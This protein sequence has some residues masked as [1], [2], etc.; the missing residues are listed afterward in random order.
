[1]RRTSCRRWL[2]SFGLLGTLLVAAACSGGKGGGNGGSVSRSI[3]EGGTLRLG[4]SQ[5]VDSLNPFV[6]QNQ[7]AGSV[8]KNVYPYLVQFDT[9]MGVVGDFAT[10]WET[11]SDGLTWTFHTTPNAK[12]SDGQP[13]TA[14]DAAFSLRVM[15]KFKSG[16][17]ALYAGYAAGISGVQATD[18]NTLVVTYEKP[19]ATALARLNYIPILPEH[20]WSKYAKGNGQALKTFQ[21]PVPVVSGGPLVP[22]KYIKN[23]TVVLTKNANW[24]GPKVHVDEV[25]VEMFDNDDAMVSALKTGQ[26][27]AI[28]TPGVPPT[29]VGTLKQAGFV[30]DRAPGL[31]LRYILFNSN[32]KKTV[33]RELLEPKVKEA[34]A[35]AVDRTRIAQVA[36]LG[37]AEPG[38]SVVPPADGPWHDPSVKPETFDLTLANQM[39]DQAGYPKGSDGIRVANGHK[40]AYTVVFPKDQ[41]GAGDRAF[42]IIQSDFRQIGVQLQ[43]K[44]E[45]PSAAFDSITAPSSKYLTNDMGM[46]AWVVDPDPDFI[47][48]V[49]TCGQ[50]ASLSDSGYCNPQYEALYKKQASMI[51]QAAR[52]QVVYQMQQML[53]N[54]RP[55]IVYAYP[56]IVEAHAKN[57]AG[58]VQSPQGALNTLS[59]LTVEQVHQVG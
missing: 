54:E 22:V 25:G 24:Y 2:V 32:T 58:F 30:I 51:D 21:N 56:D 17:A 15:T 31:A 7:S 47:L 26:I 4:T 9:T 49:F 38:G 45:D 12:W 34:F 33:D 27:D 23:Q 11:S 3:K 13:L 29:A 59:K 43:Q 5:P 50:Y 55:Y 19:S 36:F 1:M 46:W 37:F 16:P 57:W 41:Q 35:H 8:L 48:S 6:F 28:I 53:F 42:Q 40:M 18:A 10:K 44:V 39:L 52:R 14:E 20:V